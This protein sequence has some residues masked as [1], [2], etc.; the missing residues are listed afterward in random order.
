MIDIS[1]WFWFW[2]GFK[3][4]ACLLG[5]I[6]RA[7]YRRG[8]WCI[9]F[10]WGTLWS[11]VSRTI[12]I[13][14][15]V[16]GLPTLSGWPIL[17]WC[18]FFS[19]TIHCWC[20]QFDYITLMCFTLSNP[21]GRNWAISDFGGLIDSDRVGIP[22]NFLHLLVG[23]VR[24]LWNSAQDS[25]VVWLKLWFGATVSRDWIPEN[26]NECDWKPLLPNI[27]VNNMR[28]ILNARVSNFDLAS[29]IFEK[30]Y[31]CWSISSNPPHNLTILSNSLCSKNQKTILWWQSSLQTLIFRDL[32]CLP[33]YHLFK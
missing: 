12:V 29:A 32:W 5:I 33:A 3:L 24:S 21:D 7:H 15:I 19:F 6:I 13:I 10:G 9:T 16:S 31:I 4:V 17:G 28:D 27:L 18:V 14:W 8:L 23:A 1:L 30:S 20:F 26:G 22:V 25:T 2:G 11:I